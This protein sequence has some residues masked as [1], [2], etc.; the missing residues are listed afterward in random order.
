MT[1]WSSRGTLDEILHS[2]VDEE[3]YIFA[4]LKDTVTL[5]DPMGKLRA[6]FKYAASVEYERLDKGIASIEKVDIEHKSKEELFAEFFY[7][8]NGKELNAEQKEIIHALLTKE[9]A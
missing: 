9:D 3:A 1:L 2:K 5:D 4:V 7:Q 8:Q 6:R